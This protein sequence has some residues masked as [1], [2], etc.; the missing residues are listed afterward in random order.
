MSETG[1]GIR[2]D[3]SEVTMSEKPG[4]LLRPP[5]TWPNIPGYEILRELGRGGMGIVYRARQLRP[6]RTVA[7]KMILAG[8]ASS[9]DDHLRF[10]R[11]VEAIALLQHPNLVAIYEVGEYD[12]QPYFAMEH[13]NGGC[14]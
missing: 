2:N 5:T 13:V 9:P 1:V 7:L 3:T 8:R 12:G 11:E 14:L 4:A 10:L 6:D